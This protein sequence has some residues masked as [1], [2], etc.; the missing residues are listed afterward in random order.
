MRKIVYVTI[1][2]AALLIFLISIENEEIP[3]TRMCF[4]DICFD[5]WIA[6]TDAKK[7]SG[8]MNV[9]YLSGN[10]GMLFVFATEE[11]Y[12]FWMKDTLIPL[13]MVWI[14][15][16]LEVVDITPAVPCTSDP[17]KLYYPTQNAMYV[18]EIAPGSNV[19]IGDTLKIYF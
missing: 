12:T 2:L 7:E 3:T 18:L 16:K 5:A 9:G 10:Q 14:N 4:D 11:N 19:K 15:S 13:D 1:V 6:N 8:L 17:C